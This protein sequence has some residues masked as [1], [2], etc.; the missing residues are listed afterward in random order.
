MSDGGTRREGHRTTVGSSCSR[1]GSGRTGKS[2]LPH[3]PGPRG[4]AASRPSQRAGA[5]RIV[6]IAETGEGAWWARGGGNPSV[7]SPLDL[8]PTAPSRAVAP[9]DCQK[10]SCISH[11]L[12]TAWGE[13]RI[14]NGHSRRARKRSLKFRSGCWKTRLR[15]RHSRSRSSRKRTPRACS[16]HRWKAPRARQ[17][18]FFF[19]EGRVKRPS[20]LEVS[21]Q[22]TLEGPGLCP[23]GGGWCGGI[24]VVLESPTNAITVPRREVS[25]RSGLGES[26]LPAPVRACGSLRTWLRPR[27]DLARETS[28]GVADAVERSLGFVPRAKRSYPCST[29]G[30]QAVSGRARGS[31]GLQKSTSGAWSRPRGHGS[32]SLAPRL[33][34]RAP[35]AKTRRKPGRG[36]ESHPHA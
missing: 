9:G 30:D 13:P 6:L 14:P 4:S 1:S 35:R 34:G 27:P 23:A 10:A 31:T 11:R 3:G 26:G 7:V 24:V 5:P 15:P 25:E 17:I 33:G 12:S 29:Q 19:A 36:G 8:L 18:P 28:A 16:V 21:A 2:V 20:A 22:A 32:S